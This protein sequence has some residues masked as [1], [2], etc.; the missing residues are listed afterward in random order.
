[1]K[2]S[3]ILNTIVA[4]NHLL[5]TVYKSTNNITEQL[6][7]IIAVKSKLEKHENHLIKKLGDKK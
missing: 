2:K 1:M 5:M 3:L 4:T 7:L 6:A